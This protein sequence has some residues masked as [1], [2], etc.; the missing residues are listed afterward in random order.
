MILLNF[1]THGKHQIV[2]PL[3][4]RQRKYV[5]HYM[6]S[7][8]KIGDEKATGKHVYYAQLQSVDEFHKVNLW[9]LSITWLIRVLLQF[10]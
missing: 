10:L 8:L 5:D 2:I 7:N 1:L 4:L 3:H 9:Y 6:K